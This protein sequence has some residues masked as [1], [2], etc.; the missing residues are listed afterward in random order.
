MS[1]LSQLQS[2]SAAKRENATNADK[3]NAAKKRRGKLDTKDDAK[4]NNK[5]DVHPLTDAVF[6][7]KHREQRRLAAFN[8]AAIIEAH[9]QEF[10]QRAFPSKPAVAEKKKTQGAP[11]AS[12]KACRQQSKVDCIIYVLTHWQVGVKLHEMDPGTERDR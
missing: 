12:I 11:A 3:N 1:S 2:T 7:G 9:C 8:T 4:Y 10:M 5:E 6:G